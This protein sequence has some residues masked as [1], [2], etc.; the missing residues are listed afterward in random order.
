M[1]K[2]ISDIEILR[3]NQRLIDT[4][5][6]VFPKYHPQ[7]SYPMIVFKQKLNG[8]FAS[9][10]EIITTDPV[11]EFKFSFSVAKNRV[12][13][14]FHIFENWYCDSVNTRTFYQHDDNKE[15]ISDI[16]LKS[17][18]IKKSQSEH[19]VSEKE[20]VKFTY[21]FKGKLSSIMIYVMFLE[22]TI[23][24]FS[25]IWGYDKQGS[26]YQLTKFR[27][28]DVVSKKNNLSEEYLIL[29]YSPIKIGN[30]I[31]VDYEISKMILKGQI[32]QYEQVEQI[33]EKGLSWS[34]NSR[35]DDIL[36]E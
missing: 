32:I 3:W 19:L 11:Q 33:S 30:D 24:I 5:F 8:P 34:R 31:F 36:E 1:N 35:I 12:N 20:Y 10:G 9:S 2:F 17:L 23:E 25:K 16:D 15:K 28:G 21:D 27:I 14:F 22:D 4:S 13:N 7:S 6:M 26:E 29:D 18:T